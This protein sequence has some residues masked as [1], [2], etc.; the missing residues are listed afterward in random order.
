MQNPRKDTLDLLVSK[1]NLSTSERD[2]LETLGCGSTA[3]TPLGPLPA[4][5]SGHP[6]VANGPLIGRGD[7]FD[8]LMNLFVVEHRRV[9]TVTGIEGVGKTHLALDVAGALH[10]Q[11][12]TAVLWT[13]L[14]EG[15][16]PRS[17]Q[18]ADSAL[19]ALRVRA[20]LSA[21]DEGARRIRELVG[22]RDTLI[23]LDGAREAGAMTRAFPQVLA[24][25]PGLRV[26]ITMRNPAAVDAESL[27]PLAPLSVP[28][29]GSEHEPAMAEQAASV[30]MF[31]SQ[32]KQTRPAFR[33]SAQNTAAVV[34]ICRSLD[35]LPAALELGARWALVYSPQQLTEQ[36][37]VDPLLLTRPPEGSPWAGGGMF[38][39]IPSAVEAL[40]S[41]QRLLLTAM[42]RRLGD[43]SVAEA[44]AAAG[45]GVVESAADL[46]A[47]LVR[48]LIRRRD[49][50]D[51]SLF[52][53][54][55][56]VRRVLDD[57]DRLPV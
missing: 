16:R 48:G 41:R 53:L 10:E 57:P 8:A 31:L 12:G 15:E 4:A 37:A 1:L 17:R 35:G 56:I 32:M 45:T 34:G 36:L 44:A 21:G 18:D 51:Q 14:A 26:L 19:L 3:A 27:F 38:A 25:C 50:R 42:A 43:W 49:C 2:L 13:G 39:S 9:I 29:V 40:S 5:E 20:L 24:D 23:V 46:Y 47:L 11:Q 22:D 33:L 6:P 52:T 7:E 30:R 28:D 55:N 54:L